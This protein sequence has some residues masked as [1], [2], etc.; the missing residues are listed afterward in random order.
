M[1]YLKYKRRVRRGRNPLKKVTGAGSKAKQ[2]NRTAKVASVVGLAKQ[3][4]RI[5]KQMRKD[6][7][8][9]YY[10]PAELSSFNIGQVNGATASGAVAYELDVCNIGAG[11]NDTERIG[12]KI[13]LT[14]IQLRV[15]LTQMDSAVMENRVYIDI[16]RTADFG[17]SLANVPDLLY[18]PDSISGVVDG[19]STRYNNLRK[20]WQLI[21]SKRVFMPYDT[22]TNARHFKDF[23]MF[24][25]R[26]DMLE[27]V[28]VTTDLP[29]NYKYIAVFR[30]QN[31][32]RS[33]ATA[34]T[35]SSVPA[36]GVSTGVLV[37]FQHTDWFVDN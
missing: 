32:N 31:G 37:R 14:G 3:V 13:K 19:N 18:Q 9:K 34:S 33:T 7:E 36:Q 1:P 2:Y 21:A 28:G 30:C 11:V 8:V 12:T 25:K 17:T 16:F 22:L 20:T 6:T 5:K 24:I 10:S 26:R 27:Y 15:Q 29:I 35:L 4:N 23:K